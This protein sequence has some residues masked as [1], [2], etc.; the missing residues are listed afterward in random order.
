MAFKT[1]TMYVFF[2]E[3]VSILA[4]KTAALIQQLAAVLDIAY[5]GSL[6]GGPA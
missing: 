1:A 6:H 2:A 3:L 4:V 5:Y